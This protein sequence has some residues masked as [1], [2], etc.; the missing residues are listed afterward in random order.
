MGVE[1]L[2]ATSEYSKEEEGRRGCVVR[3]GSLVR[4]TATHPRDRTL[5]LSLS[6]GRFSL[7]QLWDGP[8]VE[9]RE[10]G[11]EGREDQ[12]ERSS[13][14][15]R[16]DERSGERAAK[17][18]HLARMGEGPGRANERRHGRL[19][20]WGALGGP[21]RRETNHHVAKRNHLWATPATII[22]R[23]GHFPLRLSSQAK[24]LVSPVFK[25]SAAR[26]ASTS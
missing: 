7:T 17:C 24:S 6:L 13:A 9:R 8:E 15:C 4:W 5:S 14:Q 21:R 19:Q 1:G 23:V 20:A 12:A 11:E 26:L 25:F 18:G 22:R 16:C 2:W 10:G 3:G